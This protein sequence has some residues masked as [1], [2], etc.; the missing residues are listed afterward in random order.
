MTPPDLLVEPVTTAPDGQNPVGRRRRPKRWV[1]VAAAT[2]ALTVVVVG[3]W[4]LLRHDGGSEP[5]ASRPGTKTVPVTRQD[6]V[7]RQSVDGTIGYAGSYSAVNQASGT[8]TA[9]PDKGAVIEAG[10]TLYRVDQR[11]IT[12]LYGDVPAWRALGE[13]VSDGA[14]V[15]QL[16][17]N[18]VALGHATE[19]QLAVDDKFTS[20]TTAAV[21][22]WQKA[23]GVEQSGVVALGEV[24]FLPT[25]IRVADTQATKGAP[26]QPGAPVLTATSTTRV[27][28]VD[29]DA[30]KQALVEVGDKVEVELPSGRTTSG[31][32]AT[33]GSVAERQGEGATAQDV[34]KV[35][36]SLDDP[37]ATGTLDQ[38]PVEVR[39]ES[40]SRQ[41]V[42]IVPVNALLALREGGY[43]VRVVDGTHTRIVAVE[44]GLFASGMVEVT[45]E[46]LSE[47][48]LVEV[49]A[50]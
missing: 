3:L 1:V 17:A 23:I 20:A 8:I 6:L 15:R 4:T 25:A 11:P 14:D 35:T 28:Q 7:A 33:V 32:V 31:T 24:V 21:R 50:T 34:I 39:I 22:R 37:A 41:G 46:G 38:A 48:M 30:Q 47:G 18:L 12:L 26:A 9:L 40:D 5:A 36:I 16:E 19:R 43:G 10:Q 49:P 2:T 29:L 42:L 13:G 45:G 44:T 27:V